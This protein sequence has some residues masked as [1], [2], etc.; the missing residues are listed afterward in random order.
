VTAILEPSAPVRGHAL[1]SWDEHGLPQLPRGATCVGEWQ[2]PDLPAL[3]RARHELGSR[4]G[5]QAVAGRDAVERLLLAFE[6]LASNGVRHGRGVVTVRVVRSAAGW[7]IDV[8][9]A[10]VDRPPVLAVDRDPARGGM[11]LAMVARLC[12]AH[13]W[14]V[15][16][17]SKH[18]WACLPLS[19]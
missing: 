4:L 10:A 1:V 19:A 13:G 7:L 18:V 9:D 5:S 3:T 6:E 11:G 14:S 2:L 15:T 17:G 12:P 16:G 8:A